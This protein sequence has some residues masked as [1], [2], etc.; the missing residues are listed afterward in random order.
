MSK[1]RARQRAEKLVRSLGIQ[2]APIDVNGIAK[3][4][5]LQVMFEDLGD[6]GDRVSGMLISTKSGACIVV[7]RKD[8]IHR[9]RFSVAH[10]I[11]HHVLGH[12]F[13]PGEHVHVDHGI[14]VSLRDER[15][16]EG[17][18][19]KEIE[20]NQFAASLLM[21]RELIDRELSRRELRRIDLDLDIPALAE[22]FKVSE[23][24]MTIRLG[25]LG[26]IS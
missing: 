11:G 1:L 20:A 19:P 21:P 10:E 9:R 15:T 12:Q 22:S 13:E 17:I 8:H 14:F 4:L 5:G 16:S 18:D 24:A 2:D 26:H 6:S 7:N 25:A 3:A 23:Q